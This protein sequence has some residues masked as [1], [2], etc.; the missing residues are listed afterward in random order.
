VYSRLEN[1]HAEFG[2][3]EPYKFFF[4]QAS[5]IVLMT[6]LLSPALSATECI[7]FQD[8]RQHI[9]ATRCVTGKVLR[10][11][12]GDK[13]VTYLDFC[14]DYRVCPFTVVVFRS[15][16]SHVG[17]VR[18]LSGKTIEIHGDLKEYD[19]RAEIILSRPR[20]L[21]GDAALIPP[22]PKTYD[23]ERKGRYSAGK[24]SRPKTSRKTAPKRQSKPVGIEDPS[25]AQN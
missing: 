23:V 12:E 7:S 4:W 2:A 11:E 10:V 16:L 18:R 1:S 8:A 21:A 13:G 3:A 25:D 6:G 24:F 17:D 15:D 9:G 20:Q 5:F 22:L 14:E 19:G